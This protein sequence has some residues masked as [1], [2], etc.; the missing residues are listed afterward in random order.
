MEHDEVEDH[1]LDVPEVEYQPEGCEVPDV[2][3]SNVSDVEPHDAAV[4]LKRGRDEGYEVPDVEPKVDVHQEKKEKEYRKGE[5]EPA[6][7]SPASSNI[8]GMS[9]QKNEGSTDPMA[10]AEDLIAEDEPPKASKGFKRKTKPRAP[11]SNL[12]SQDDQPLTP[13]PE[14][15]RSPQDHDGVVFDTPASPPPVETPDEV[16]LLLRGEMETRWGRDA[17]KGFPMELTGELSGKIKN[18]ILRKYPP[19]VIFS[20]I[21]CL[22][23]DWEVARGVCFPFRPTARYPETLALVQYAG[24]LASRVTTGFDYMATRRGALNT[25]HDLFV[26]KIPFIRDDDPF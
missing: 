17:I 6:P 26:R 20:M 22:V 16:V 5:Y 24:E 25:Y 4:A 3:P 14:A 21:R 12:V 1:E 19:D 8:L 9:L 2:E 11:R 15:M 23:W 10:E 13:F 7:T 18:S